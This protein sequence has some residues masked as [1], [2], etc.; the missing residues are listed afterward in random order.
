[1]EVYDR[2]I[3]RDDDRYSPVV[4]RPRDEYYDDYDDYD[5]RDRKRAEVRTRKQTILD[6][7]ETERIIESD[8]SRRGSLLL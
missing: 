4:I 6:D 5:R 7:G 1:M 8:K 2:D 3:V